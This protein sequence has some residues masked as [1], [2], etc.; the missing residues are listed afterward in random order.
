MWKIATKNMKIYGNWSSSK[1]A[2]VGFSEIIE[3]CLNLGIRASS[4]V[5]L[6]SKKKK[7]KKWYKTLCLINFCN[8]NNVVCVSERTVHISKLA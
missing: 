7:K 2:V 6:S 8:Y 5:T 1:S 4:R 3:I